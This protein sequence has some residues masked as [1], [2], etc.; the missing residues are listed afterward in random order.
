MHLLLEVRMLPLEICNMGNYNTKRLHACTWT[1]LPPRRWR[2][3]PSRAT[4]YWKYPQLSLSCGY[5]T[6]TWHMCNS[7]LTF[8]NDFHDQVLTANIWAYTPRWAQSPYN[9]NR[10]MPIYCQW[11]RPMAK[12]VCSQPLYEQHKNGTSSL[13]WNIGQYGIGLA[14]QG[15]AYCCVLARCGSM[16]PSCIGETFRDCLAVIEKHL[17]GRSDSHVTTRT[18]K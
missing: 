8:M 10:V 5:A 3:V 7:F 9:G 13:P 17:T 15:E 4:Y 16:V 11:P 2:K 14:A 1:K 18:K 6:I 12:T